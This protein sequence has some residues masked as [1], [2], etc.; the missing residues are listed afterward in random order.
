MSGCARCRALGGLENSLHS[1]RSTCQGVPGI[2]LWEDYRTAC[3]ALGQHVRVCQVSTSGR[4]TEQPA[5]PSVNMS[6]CA[7]GRTT[8]QPAKPSVNMSG[9]ARCRPLRG[10]QNSLQSPRW[11]CQGVP[12]VDLWEDYRTA[13]TALGQHVRVCQMSTFRSVWKAL[14]PTL[15]ISKPSS[16]LCWQCQRNMRY[17]R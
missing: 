17:L 16:D 1:P 14:M 9:C 3:T 10:L 11:T 15:I 5:Q 6:G 8:E 12:G 4:T 2:D 7:S 13:C